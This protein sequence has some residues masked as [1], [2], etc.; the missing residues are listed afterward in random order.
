MSNFLLEWNEKYLIL[1]KQ[2]HPKTPSSVATRH[3]LPKGRRENQL[4][5][6]DSPV[7]NLSKM[8]NS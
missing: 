1:L 3:L 5:K 2:R 8:K 6:W 7:L 4:F